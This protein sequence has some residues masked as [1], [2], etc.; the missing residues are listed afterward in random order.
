MVGHESFDEGAEHFRKLACF[1]DHLGGFAEWFDAEFTAD[2]L[3]DHELRA[4][5]TART[6]AVFEITGEIGIRA[7][8][9]TF[10][11]VRRNG[12]GRVFWLF[13]SNSFEPW[14]ATQTFTASRQPRFQTSRFSKL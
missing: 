8:F 6:F 1:F 11:D 5:L 9:R 10:R 3:V 13:S 4:K 7:A 14:A 12:Q 2:F